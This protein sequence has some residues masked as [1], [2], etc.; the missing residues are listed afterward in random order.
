MLFYS[1]IYIFFFLPALLF[2]YYLIFKNFNNLKKIIIIFSIVF[3]AWW[4]II[5]LPLIL[6]IIIVNYFFGNLII[7]NQVSKRI[8]FLSAIIVNI[9]N[10]FIF[11]YINFFIENFNLFTDA[12]INHVNFDF[13][14]GISFY[15]FQIITYLSDCYYG[16][17][18]KTKF[19]D[20][21]LFVIFFPQLV[22]G[23]IIRFNFLMSQFSDKIN[24]FNINNT[25]NGL[26]L[27]FIG[28]IK[29]VY[30]SNQ[31]SI[32]V[33]NN[34]E[35]LDNLTLM[36]SWLT[37]MSFS[38]QFYFDFSGYVDMALG[39][40]LLLNIKLPINFNSPFKAHNLINFW[41]RWHITLSNFIMNYMYFPLLKNYN[42]SNYYLSLFLTIIIFSVI[43][44]WHGPSW[45]FI[46]FGVFHGI[47][48]VF[49]HLVNR[50]TDFNFPRIISI[51]FTFLYVNFSFIFFRSE[52]IYQS[53][54]II[55][56]MFNFQNL[57][58]F[59][60]EIKFLLFFT[61]SFIIVFFVKNSNEIINYLIS[62]NSSNDPQ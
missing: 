60:Y 11:K 26:I 44:F 9:I 54:K 38:F 53:K 36:D 7:N 37:S 58:N 61:T 16:N 22:A 13:P 8:Y 32:F 15:T 14:L 23:P 41:Q 29:K 34:F 5:Y 51:I 25:L 45:M 48:V 33:D 40:A 19:F 55:Y 1:N 6:F 59:N 21:F 46:L 2:S 3:Y 47:G 31:L 62:K 20:F 17:I 28:F 42:I 4:N 18:K 10:L 12:N 57:G 27:F 30:L 56:N 50:L 43:G 49:N 39:S 24:V 35:N 52:N